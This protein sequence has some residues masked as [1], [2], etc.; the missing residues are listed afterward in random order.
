MIKTDHKPLIYAF[1]K[2]PKKAS[3]RQLRHLDYVSQFTTEM[4]YLSGPANTVADA[5]SRLNAISMPSTISMGAFQSAPELD[6]VL[7]TLL[8]G[9]NSLK[10][11]IVHFDST[12][13]YCD[14]ST[15]YVR[16]MYLRQHIS[17]ITHNMSHPNG[18]A[19]LQQIRKRYVWSAMKKQIINWS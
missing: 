1:S 13:V 4:I 10:L 5:L 2:K 12:S 16:P 14:V 18:K 19:T 11:Q 9:D 6:E 8:E 15:G 3:P 7:K 17:D